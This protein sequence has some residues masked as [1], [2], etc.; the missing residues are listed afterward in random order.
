LY[1]ACGHPSEFEEN[2]QRNRQEKENELV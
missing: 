2:Q 1:S